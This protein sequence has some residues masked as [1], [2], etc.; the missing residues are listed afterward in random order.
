MNFIRKEKE[1]EKDYSTNNIELK[2]FKTIKE[3]NKASKKN[4]A[5]SPRINQI[6]VKSKEDLKLTN[7]R[8]KKSKSSKQLLIK[9]KSD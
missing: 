4:N 2:S 5:K 3:Q 9:L 1:E 7:T 8:S 6:L